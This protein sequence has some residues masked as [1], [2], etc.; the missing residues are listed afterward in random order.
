MPDRLYASGVDWMTLETGK[1]TANYLISCMA[2]ST[3]A[4]ENNVDICVHQHVYVRDE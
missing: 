3:S 4:D 1:F 2:S